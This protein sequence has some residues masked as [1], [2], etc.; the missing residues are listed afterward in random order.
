MAKALP[1]FVSTADSDLN[2][3]FAR[4]RKPLGLL[5]YFAYGWSCL[6]DETPWRQS[7][8]IRLFFHFAA[9]E[10]Y[11]RAQEKLHS[12]HKGLFY[13]QLIQF[14]ADILR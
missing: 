3:E 11:S 14:S 7:P 12:L 2:F 9:R 8:G 10:I 1:R 5:Q 6:T 13:H 4:D